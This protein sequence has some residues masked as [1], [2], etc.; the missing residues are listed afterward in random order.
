MSASAAQFQFAAEFVTFLAAAAGLALVL[1]RSELLSDA[2]WGRAALALG[3][4]CMGSG[5]FLHGSRLVTRADEPGLLVLAAGAVLLLAVGSLRWRGE[6]AAQRLLQAGLVLEAAAVA[7]DAAR[8][9]TVPAEAVRG[10]GAALIGAGLVI[11]SRRAIA[12]RV[13]ASAALTLLLVVLVLSVALSAVLTST[14]RDQAVSRLDSRARGESTRAAGAYAPLLQDALVT[15]AS[16]HGAN[17]DAQAAAGNVTALAQHVATLQRTFLTQDS[18]LWLSPSRQVLAIAP[19]SGLASLS[20]DRGL[21][22]A[23]AGSPVVDEA[24]RRAA[25]VGSDLTVGTHVLGVAAS[26]ALFGTPPD[27]KGVA[28]AVRPL[29]PN[30]LQV[31]ASDDP[32]LSLALVGRDASLAQFGAQPSQRVLLSLA[33]SVLDRGSPGTARTVG[34]RYVV[35]RPVLTSTNVPFAALVAST[36]TTAVTHTRD[37]LF[38]TLFSIALGGTLLALLLAAAVGDRIGAGLR[39]LTVAA[40]GIQRGEVGV[41]TGFRGED[42]VGLLGAAFDSMAGSIED[43]TAAL[44]QA[45]DEETRLRNRLEA[46]VAGMGEALVAVDADGAVTDVNRAA[47][48]LLGVTA[49]AARGRPATEV[50]ALMGEEGGDLREQLRPSPRR[51]SAGWSRTTVRAFP[52]RCPPVSSAGRIR[53]S[54]GGSSFCATCAASARSSA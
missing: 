15:S 49:A 23:L 46:V 13:A 3:L 53:R 2:G 45:A 7:M 18:L 40:G 38:R 6:E 11:A 48:E 1:L 31:E 32:L 27:L 14:V 41:R 24:I 37:S 51:W 36:P 34:G 9:A 39:R 43:K 16:V 42:E 33:R 4:A 50:V 17:V 47:E 35:V 44:R 8:A 20:T 21:A 25:Q 12:A 29:D 28:L 19:S 10:L 52:W 5:A 54:R 22:L 26:P 30:Y